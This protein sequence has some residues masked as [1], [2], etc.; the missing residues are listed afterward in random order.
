MRNLID[1]L[2]NLS[3]RLTQV[4]DCV[5]DEELYFSKLPMIWDLIDERR[6]LARRLRD[7]GPIT[8]QQFAEEVARPMV[9][10]LIQELEDAF[11]CSPALGAFSVFDMRHVPSNP[12]ELGDYG[13]TSISHIA[14]HYG[15][16]KQDTF[17]GH[18]VVAQP[19][20]P[21]EIIRREFS[22]F[23][24]QMFIMKQRA[25]ET[26][27]SDPQFLLK[28]LTDE[29]ILQQTFPVMSYFVLLSSLIPTSTACVERVF[30]LMNSICTP[31]RSSMSQETLDNIMRI[32]HEGATS[33]SD[34]QL[35][36]A[37]NHF[38]SKSRKIYV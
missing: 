26:D 28:K 34:N 29:P 37:I 7:E 11:H 36:R 38:T 1:E 9:Y 14:D 21:A 25:S 20:F 19:E 10:S 5:H 8:I 35:E 6:E 31:L 32:V 15:E 3:N 13:Q 23:K 24:H 12:L 17:M 16:A 22:A 18:H 30:S 2:E 4:G 27:L 33:L